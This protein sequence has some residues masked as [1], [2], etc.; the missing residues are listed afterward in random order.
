MCPT[1]QP[2]L[3]W[4]PAHHS[5]P[6]F[7]RVDDVYD[8]QGNYWHGRLKDGGRIDLHDHAGRYYHGKLKAGGKVELYDEEGSYYYGKLKT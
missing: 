7:W 1:D 3:P 2:I 4:L 5:G 8:P 6:E